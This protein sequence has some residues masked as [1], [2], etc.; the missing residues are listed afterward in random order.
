MTPTV[1]ELLSLPLHR[2]LITVVT[3][4]LAGLLLEGWAGIQHAQKR[5]I[6]AQHDEDCRYSCRPQDGPG[7]NPQGLPD[8]QQAFN[9]NSY[10]GLLGRCNVAASTGGASS[11]CF[12]SVFLLG[13]M[14]MV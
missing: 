5:G 13:P 11:I 12:E 7:V 4:F 2:D 9:I 6:I 10:L 1:V 14:A 3:R 8:R